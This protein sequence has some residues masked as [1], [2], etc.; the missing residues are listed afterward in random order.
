MDQ[1]KM[2]TLTP[3]SLAQ[4]TGRTAIGSAVRDPEM[5]ALCRQAAAEGIVL[6]KNEGV[7]PLKKEEETAFFGRVQNDWFYV[8]YGSGGDVNPPYRVS[9]MDA[10]REK[11]VRFHEA[12]AQTYAAWSQTH[13]PPAAEWAQWP[14]SLEEMPLSRKQIESAAQTSE[15][16]VVFLGRAMGESMDNQ[17]MPGYFYLTD[18]EKDLL[19]QVSTVFSKTVVVIDAGSILDMSWTDDPKIGAILYAF[20]GGMESGNALADVLYG[21]VNPSGR[22]T[23]TVARCYEDYPASGNFGAAD[24][25]V[26]QEDIYVGYRYFETFARNRVLY[27][28]GFGLS[29]TTFALKTCYALEDGEC[30]LRTAVTNTGSLPG[31]E[32]VQVYAAPPQGKLGKPL[33]NLAAFGKTKLLSPGE[34]ETL[35]FRLNPADFASFDDSGVTG[36]KS[37]YVLEPGDY[38]LYVGGDVR[39]ARQAGVWRLDALRVTK[40]LTAQ[41][42]P[43][44]EFLRMKP[45]E[46]ASG[47]VPVYEPVLRRETSR[48][49]DILAHLPEETPF[50][51]DRGIG[52]AD[53]RNGSASL[54]D[55]VAQLDI[56]EL[57]AITRGEGLMDSPLGPAGNAGVLGGTTASLRERGVPTI[58]TT[59]GPSG[60]RLAC[61]ASLLPCGTA[62]ASSWNPAL[63]EKL[64]VRFGREMAE[65]GSD[66]LLGPGLNIHRDPLCGRNFEYYSEDPYVSGVMAAAMVRGVQ[67]NP[68]RSACPK[69]FACNNQEWM[70]N[71]TDSRVSERALREIYLR[72]FELCVARAKPLTLMTSYNKVNG[73][74]AHYHYDLVTNILRGE[75]GYDG[76]VITDWWMQP[77]V[78]P[79]FPDVSNNA[80]R[81]RAQV[82]VLMPGGEAF[83]CFESDDS[84]QRSFESPDGI[85][86]GE[87]QRGAKNVLR[88]CERLK[89]KHC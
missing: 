73:V 59:D 17:A 36:H 33:R 4:K 24:Y 74:W 57:D 14:A 61:Y 66:I 60:I 84:L 1:K 75:W 53:V 30:I 22:L 41:A 49:A 52:F 47:L 40:Q 45:Q 38:M 21:D 32:V 27:P 80:Y 48:K 72:G 26:Y 68:G 54:D 8:G 12:L 71:Q 58:T 55:F 69:H 37:A 35:E 7:L 42:A 29:Y 19:N 16:A 87:L 83:G 31:K 5:S 13:V 2:E 77:A 65:R 50:T 63:V 86:L 9:P 64:G 88:L 44:A 79:D 15:T 78:D 6:L 76:L 67:S 89:W 3:D 11:G 46:T 70:R 51:G 34:T 85:T 23:D 20:Q 10:F 39:M 56:R 81:V 28:F 18:A 62:L 82:D 43:T 25:N